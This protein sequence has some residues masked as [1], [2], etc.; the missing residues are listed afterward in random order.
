M[1]SVK[2]EIEIANVSL[3]HKRPEAE[4]EWEGEGDT[5]GRNEAIFDG[6]L[7]VL[8]GVGQ[9]VG[10]GRWVAERL[11]GRH[12]E[13]RCR[14]RRVVIVVKARALLK[15]VLAH[16][17]AQLLAHVLIAAKV[18]IEH[19]REGTA[20]MFDREVSQRVDGISGLRRCQRR[21]VEGCESYGSI[22]TLLW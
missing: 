9:C 6:S 3:R 14:I 8:L 13:D 12:D 21:R 5:D 10:G 17:V 18:D 11:E 19:E 20:R 16:Q 2:I 7:E 15:D 22:R 4:W 1:S